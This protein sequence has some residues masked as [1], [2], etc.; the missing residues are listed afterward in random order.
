MSSLSDLLARKAELEKHI[1][2]LQT[3]A[4]SDAI[5]QVKALMADHG[6]GVADL[7]EM[8]AG[9]K[10]KSLQAKGETVAAKYRNEATGETWS[11]RG[12]RPKWLRAEIEAGRKIE[13]FAA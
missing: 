8:S 6:V 4:R 10:S 13:D 3:T 7:A 11:G 9:R 5:A 12:P 1:E 2:T